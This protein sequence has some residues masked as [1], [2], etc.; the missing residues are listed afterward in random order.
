L[1]TWRIRLALRP[2]PTPD[3]VGEQRRGNLSTFARQPD[4]TVPHRRSGLAFG[5]LRNRERQQTFFVERLRGLAGCP[6]RFGDVGIA[7]RETL[8]LRS[9]FT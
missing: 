7:C 8:R 3:A 6:C 5:E 2:Q 9:R 4:V 1:T